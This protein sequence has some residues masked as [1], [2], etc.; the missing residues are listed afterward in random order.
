MVP[1]PKQQGSQSSLRILL[2]CAA[3]PELSK[4]D[5]RRHSAGFLAGKG[6]T[7]VNPT[8]GR[9]GAQAQESLLSVCD[10]YLPLVHHAVASY[11]FRLPAHVDVDELTGAATL[12]LVEAARRFDPSRGVPFE[13]WALTRIRGAILDA[14]RSADPA[15]RS[16]RS[17]ARTVDAVTS[18]LTQRLGRQ[19]TDQ[20]L[21]AELGMTQEDLADLRA[22]VHRGIVLSLDGLTTDDDTSTTFA[23]TLVDA[24]LPPL[25]ALERR[26]LDAYV[27]DCVA[28]LPSNLRLVITE[29]FLNGK[30]SLDIAAQLGVSESRVSQLRS[31]ALKVLRHALGAQYDDLFA[32]T[33]RSVDTMPSRAT[34]VA[35][36]AAAKSSYAQRLSPSQASYL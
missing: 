7:F 27:R 34:T 33:S 29:Y 4:S 15:S 5:T 1:H 22:K 16:T 14:A 28:S 18:E 13:P 24:E 6:H 26:E 21:T 8:I 20:E 11:A 25:E 23:E 2:T 9:D 17:R 12:G 32:R 35:S 19:P 36:T 31:E 30:T 3:S 10:R